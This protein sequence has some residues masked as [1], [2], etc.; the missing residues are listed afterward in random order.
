MLTARTEVETRLKMLRFGVN[1]YV[2][3]PFDEGELLVR[4]A[5]YAW[6]AAN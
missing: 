3:K 4:L 2:T 1:D 6:A 5:N